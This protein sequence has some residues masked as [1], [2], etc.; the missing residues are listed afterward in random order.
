M[1]IFPTERR[2]P[3]LMYGFRHLRCPY[4]L[5]DLGL[6]LDKLARNNTS[7]SY[8]KINPRHVLDIIYLENVISPH[9]N[10][11]NIIPISVLG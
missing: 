10:L 2:T 9:T 7:F 11:L 4:N 8:S 1:K 6:P 5:R 3:I